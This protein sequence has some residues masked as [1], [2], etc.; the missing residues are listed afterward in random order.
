MAN[1][2]KAVETIKGIQLDTIFLELQSRK[3]KCFIPINLTRLNLFYSQ[4]YARS[5]G[6]K[7][8]RNS[9]LAFL[10]ETHDDLV[11]A[12]TIKR[13]RSPNYSQWDF[14]TIVPLPRDF[15]VDT[16]NKV[17]RSKQLLSYLDVFETNNSLS[18]GR[19]PMKYYYAFDMIEEEYFV[20]DAKTD[21][22]YF[23]IKSTVVDESY[24]NRDF[25]AFLYDTI[26][27]YDVNE[28]VNDRHYDIEEVVYSYNLNN[29]GMFLHTR[30]TSMSNNIV[31]IPY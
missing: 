2:V 4:F 20:E 18:F 23:I 16:D 12:V 21:L 24:S 17:E 25:F 10:F 11:Y 14:D 27:S 19:E 6:T 1:N 5:I 29:F 31:R 9:G 8:G 22:L 15:A 13:H 26:A 30:I 3:F 28:D 7:G